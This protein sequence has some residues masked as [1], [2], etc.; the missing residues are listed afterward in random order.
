MLRSLLAERS[1]DSEPSITL[2]EEALFKGEGKTLEPR[3][4]R[5]FSFNQEHSVSEPQFPF[6]TLPQIHIFEKVSQERSVA[7]RK[8][9]QAKPKGGGSTCHNHHRDQSCRRR[10]MADGQGGP[11]GQQESLLGESQRPKDSYVP[12]RTRQRI[13][14]APPPLAVP[15]IEED[16]DERKRVLNV[17]AQRRYSMIFAPSLSFQPCT[18]SAMP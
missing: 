16:A 12:P 9:A 3:L 5:F 8:D 1:S 18:L 4:G 13:Y 14:K 6:L 10:S 2:S 17:L 15:D 7:Q 11:Q